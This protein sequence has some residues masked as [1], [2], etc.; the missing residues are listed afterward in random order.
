MTAFTTLVL[1]YSDHGKD[2]FAKLLAERLRLKA[3]GSSDYACEHFIFQW[4]TQHFPGLYRTVDE[5]HSDRDNWRPCWHQLIKQF[6]TPDKT[7]LAKDILREND[8]YIGMRDKNEVAA[9][10]GANL[11]RFYFWIDALK[12]KPPEDSSSMSIRFDPSY[13]IPVDNNGTLEDLNHTVGSVASIMRQR[14]LADDIRTHAPDSLVY[15]FTGK[16]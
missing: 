12:R 10:R 3:T 1:G 16:F 13:M 11:F 5:C 2:E 8:I 14:A 4:F 7:R 9:C 15:H 6:N